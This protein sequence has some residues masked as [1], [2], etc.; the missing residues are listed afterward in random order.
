MSSRY[1]SKDQFSYI[2]RFHMIYNIKDIAKILELPF[3]SKLYF[4]LPKT[5]ILKFYNKLDVLSNSGISY[6][7]NLD[8]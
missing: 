8:K 4:N 6:L 7:S 3:K 1:D 5:E 2:K